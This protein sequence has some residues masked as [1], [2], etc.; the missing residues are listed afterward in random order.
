MG[1]LTDIVLIVDSVRACG[2]AFAEVKRMRTTGM[3]G[4]AKKGL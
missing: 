3:N 2:K 4:S 1:W